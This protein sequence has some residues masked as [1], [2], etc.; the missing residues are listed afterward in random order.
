MASIASRNAK[1]RKVDKL[2]YHLRYIGTKFYFLYFLSLQILS[3]ISAI[4]GDDYLITIN[5]T[6][7]YNLVTE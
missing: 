3:K 5:C 7:V 2:A 6:D 4:G 1:H